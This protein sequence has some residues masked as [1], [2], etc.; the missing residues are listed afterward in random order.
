MAFE[1]DTP[2]HER[3]YAGLLRAN[4][5]QPSSV[6]RIAA[7]ELTPELFFR[8]FVSRGLPVVIVG[9]CAAWPALTNWTV[10]SLSAEET[11]VSVA[12][13]PAGRGD[14]LVDV[15]EAGSADDDVADTQLFVQPEMRTL[16]LGSAIRQL[17]SRDES[18]GIPYVAAQDDRLRKELPHLLGDVCGGDLEWAPW[19]GADADAINLWVGDERSVT[20]CHK[21]H[22][23][24][25]LSV[26]I[27]EKSLC[28]N[29][30]ADA[31]W[32]P[33]REFPAGRFRQMLDGSW[34]IDVDDASGAAIAGRAAPSGGSWRWKNSS[35]QPLSAALL[36][37]RRQRW[38]A[39]DTFAPPSRQP[40]LTAAYARSLFVSVRAGD[41][42]YLPPLWHHAVT[43]TGF[44]VAV[45]AWW[46]M[47]FAGPAYALHSVARAL[48]PALQAS[49]E[50]AAGHN[51]R[52]RAVFKN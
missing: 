2:L 43:Q 51:R 44:C 1:G 15:F 23:E 28:L 36:P 32:L 35:S 17:L 30:P 5:Q 38:L 19:R 40:S 10:S 21:D 6:P 9:G 39:V 13:S 26:I 34:V 7:S 14:D 27:G 47:D 33:E 22:Y 52:E 37:A 31:M 29:A 8:Q 18:G 45:N 3:V 12:F 46:D 16:P 48:S 41:T 24:N 25:L 49:Y 11:P 50:A 20:S 4:E 42:L